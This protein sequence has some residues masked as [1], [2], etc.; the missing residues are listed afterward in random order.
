MASSA[1]DVGESEWIADCA[2]TGDDRG[3]VQPVN[4]IIAC[5]GKGLLRFVACSKRFHRGKVV[6]AEFYALYDKDCYSKAWTPID[7]SVYGQ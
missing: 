2:D 6:L 7:D 1:D 5:D 3:I 4:R